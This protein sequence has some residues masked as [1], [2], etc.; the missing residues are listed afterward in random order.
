MDFYYHG[1]TITKLEC[2]PVELMALA[3][4]NSVEEMDDLVD[5]KC[6]QSENHGHN[7]ILQLKTLIGNLEGNRAVLDD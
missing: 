3:L 6:T 1:N 4:E 5:R 2:E 7:P